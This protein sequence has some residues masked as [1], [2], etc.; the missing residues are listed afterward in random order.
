MVATNTVSLPSAYLMLDVPFL[1]YS[2]GFAYSVCMDAEANDVWYS[3]ERTEK[4]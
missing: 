3:N 2:F 1:F 4:Y